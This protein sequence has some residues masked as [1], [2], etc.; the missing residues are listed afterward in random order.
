[1]CRSYLFICWLVPDSK[2]D[3][4]REKCVCTHVCVCTQGSVRAC[5]FSLS[6][7]PTGGRIM[8]L[9][10]ADMLPPHFSLLPRRPLSLS[11][12]FFYSL[13][14]CFLSFSVSLY[15]PHRQTQH[16]CPHLTQPHSCEARHQSRDSGGRGAEWS[17]RG[18][19]WLRLL[20]CWTARESLK[21][22]S[23]SQG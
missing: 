10:E 13:L 8:P 11:L 1:M 3:I 17:S 22:G 5:S 4:Q 6:L 9:S 16:S 23:H 2:A 7:R 12:P 20:A 18:L 14:L 19:N 21:K 15:S